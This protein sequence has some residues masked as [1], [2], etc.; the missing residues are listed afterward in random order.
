[1]ARMRQRR[2]LPEVVGDYSMADSR[3]ND[4]PENIRSGR[5]IISNR[6]NILS[7]ELTEPSPRLSTVRIMV[8]RKDGKYLCVIDHDDASRIGF[9]GGRI[10]LNELPEDAATR[11]LWEE[12]GLIANN[13]RLVDTNFFRENQI[14][15]FLANDVEGNLKSSPEG[16][17]MWCSGKDLI[18]GFFG[19][20][21]S[22]I[23]KKLGHL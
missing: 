23:L 20:Y 19:E 8:R 3:R 22:N 17:V 12:T 13:L 4:S 9:P 15:L 14:S 10:E 1:M 2:A 16:R 6:T 7:D 11:E 21:Y 5:F 18:E